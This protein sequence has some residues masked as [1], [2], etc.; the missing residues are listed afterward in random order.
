MRCPVCNR[1]RLIYW[2]GTRKNK[3]PYVGF[4]CWNAQH[5]T[6]FVNGPDDPEY[7]I[8]LGIWRLILENWPLDSSFDPAVKCPHPDCNGELY[9]TRREWFNANRGKMLA[10]YYVR[11]TEIPGH[12]H[13]FI[14]KPGWRP[15]V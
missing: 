11:C 4:R 6:G 9:G 1:D 12:F 13:F 5:F 14:N 8:T 10:G 2:A 7:P 15:P 3:A